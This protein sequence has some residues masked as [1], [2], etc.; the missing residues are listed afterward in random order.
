MFVDGGRG[1]DLRQRSAASS[2]ARRTRSTSV[3]SSWSARRRCRNVHPAIALMLMQRGRARRHAGADR[4]SDAKQASAN[5]VIHHASVSGHHATFTLSPLSVVDHGSTSGTWLA[6][7]AP[8]AE[9]AARPRSARDRRARADSGPGVPSASARA[10]SWLAP[11]RRAPLSPVPVP[12][13]PSRPPRLEL[14]RPSPSTRPSSARWRSAAPA[15]PAFKSIGRTPDNDIV[16]EPPAGVEQAR[17][18]AQ[19]RRRSSSSRTAAAPTAPTCAASASPPAS[20]SRSQ[21]GEKV[22][23]GPMP[24][25]LQV[26]AEEVAV[27]VEDSRPVGGP[28]A[29]RDR[30]LGPA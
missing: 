7:N 29:L 21:N 4:R 17:R 26:E 12:E 2:P 19:G 16:V 28:S 6:G 14:P 13:L 11:L 15:K 8:G 18:P 20:G 25:L 10:S 27:V 23:I 30:G 24:L 3:R 9:P 5:I 1:S 22:F